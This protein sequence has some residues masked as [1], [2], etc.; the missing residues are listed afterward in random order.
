MR[1]KS[2]MRPPKTMKKSILLRF[3]MS[4]YHKQCRELISAGGIRDIGLCYEHTTEVSLSR[5]SQIMR[6]YCVTQGEQSWIK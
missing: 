5:W 3:I 2:E 6:S 1:Y 4:H